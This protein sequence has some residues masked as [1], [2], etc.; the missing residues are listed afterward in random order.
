MFPGKL[1]FEKGWEFKW[2]YVLA[3]RPVCYMCVADHFMYAVA[4]FYLPPANLVFMS[5]QAHTEVL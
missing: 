4:W 1:D 5:V 3:K 2:S